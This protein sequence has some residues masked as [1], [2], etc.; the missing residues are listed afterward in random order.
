MAND[1]WMADEFWPLI[2]IRACSKLHMAHV[3]AGLR[4]VERLRFNRNDMVL[5][6]GRRAGK[7]PHPEPGQY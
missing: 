6:W 4:E 3:V 2:V 1:A 7:Y 5:D